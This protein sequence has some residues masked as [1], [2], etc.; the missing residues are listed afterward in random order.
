[1]A[2]DELLKII[3]NISINGVKPSQVSSGLHFYDCSPQIF[4]KTQINN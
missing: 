1:M 2:L 3:P 4:N